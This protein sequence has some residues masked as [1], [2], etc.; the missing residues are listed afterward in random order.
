MNRRSKEKKS[1]ALRLLAA[2]VLVVLGCCA[3]HSALHYLYPMKY[4]AAVERYCREFNVNSDL[5]FAVIHTESGF[6]PE[7]RSDAGAMGLMQIMPDT[8][9]WLQGRLEPDADMAAHRLYDPDVNLRYGIYY[10]SVLDGM[11]HDDTLTVA[12]YHAGQNKVSRWLK[13]GEIPADGCCAEDIPSAVTG[14]YVHKVQ[15][16]RS[17]YEALYG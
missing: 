17:I 4:E 5:A 13:S 1:F 11:F 12:A 16:A 10:L 14:H 8:F 2:L 7:A 3:A 15:R 6:D 9:D